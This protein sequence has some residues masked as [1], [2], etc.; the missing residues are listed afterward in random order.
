MEAG[1]VPPEDNQDFVTHE[2]AQ[3]LVK[4]AISGVTKALGGMEGR[5]MEAIFRSEERTGK[6]IKRSE[7]R[8]IDRV[9]KLDKRING[10]IKKLDG[11]VDALDAW[12]ISHT[13]ITRLFARASK[14][15]MVVTVAGT[16]LGAGLTYLATH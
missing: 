10:R 4:T 11:R 12:R 2:E 1:T 9:D 14:H 6:A 13:Y 8:G 16:L 7:E 15:P 3:Q 5:I